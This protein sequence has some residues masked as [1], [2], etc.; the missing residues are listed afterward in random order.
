MYWLKHAS[1]NRKDILKNMRG[2]TLEIARIA[3]VSGA[4]SAISSVY[5]FVTGPL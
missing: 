5:Q 4:F 2:T 3:D 1:L